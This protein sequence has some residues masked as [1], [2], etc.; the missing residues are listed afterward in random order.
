MVQNGTWYHLLSERDPM[1]FIYFSPFMR[2]PPK[3][4]SCNNRRIFQERFR[5]KDMSSTDRDPSRVDLANAYH[6]LEA[7][8]LD[9][10]TYTHLSV[11]TTHHP[12]RFYLNRFGLR[13]DEITPDNLL[14][15]FPEEPP[16]PDGNLTGV[17]LHQGIYTL[18][19]DIGA[20]FHVHTPA[21]VAVSTLPEGLRPL[22]QWALHFYDKVSYG[23]Y[24][25]LALTPAH[26][27]DFGRALGP[28]RF[29]L[30][31]KHHGAILCGRTIAEA[32]F[33]TYHLEKACQTQCLIPSGSSP[34]ELSKNVCEDAVHDLL[35]FEQDLGRRDWEA[36]VR[37]IQRSP[38][39]NLSLRTP[40]I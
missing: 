4:V 17:I 23:D 20:I 7:L 28:E 30:M 29:V 25:S 13:F 12:H 34:L 39:K 1:G 18:R 16:S 3:Q 14:E 22:S 24:S 15:I 36:W 38:F 2:L 5:G 37:W 26:G 27:E 6:I 35:T 8:G 10:H 32:M 33:Y 31:L 11:R 9:D 21:I 40:K 19:P